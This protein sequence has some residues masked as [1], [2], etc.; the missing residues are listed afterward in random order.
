M[1]I[2]KKIR[3]LR[4]SK[5][6]LQKEL[7]RKIGVTGEA[8]SFWESNIRMPRAKQIKKLAKFFGITEAELF[9]GI[10]PQKIYNVKE[11]DIPIISCVRSS[12]EFGNPKFYIFDPPYK[13]ISFKNCKAIVIDSDSTA[14]IA[15]KGQKIIFSESESVKNGDI[16][17]VKLKNGDLLFKLY[18]KNFENRTVTLQNINPSV[19]HEPI[20]LDANEIQSCHKVVAV[21]F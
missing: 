14:P 12:D 3:E 8:V 11:M 21:K 13:M 18:Y 16:V 17:F 19:S 15:Y 20:I 9:G 1:D 10:S 2:G 4:K 5:D 6:L 7:A